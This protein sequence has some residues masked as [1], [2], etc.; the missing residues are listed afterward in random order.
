MF[1]T[2]IAT[3]MLITMAPQ[4][5]ACPETEALIEQ[6]AFEIVNKEGEDLALAIL[7]RVDVP[8]VARFV[9]GR[10]ARNETTEALASFEERFERHLIYSLTDQADRFEGAD[11]DVRGSIDRNDRDSI[12]HT[13]V[14]IPGEETVS[15][16]WR[17]IQRY[18]KWK[19][20]DLEVV[21]LCLA[22]EQRAQIAVVLSDPRASVED[23]YK[24]FR[25]I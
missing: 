8:I 10:H 11:I 20:V 4:A 12:V 15:M 21:G 7:D 13:R 5:D 2:F 24:D 14:K 16:R 19:V 6:A 3:I 22:I 25:G 1:R 23:L 9:L 18:G 17:F